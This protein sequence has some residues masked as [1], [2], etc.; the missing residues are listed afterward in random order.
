MLSTSPEGVNATAFA[1][2]L[3]TLRAGQAGLLPQ[4]MTLASL[5]K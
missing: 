1:L 3:N 4:T 2:A 5:A